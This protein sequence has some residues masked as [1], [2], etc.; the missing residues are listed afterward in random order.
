MPHAHPIRELTTRR[1][2]AVALV[3]LLALVAAGVLVVSPRAAQAATEVGLGTAADF[4]VLA[5]ETITVTGPTTINGDIGLHP[6]D[7]VT[8][9]DNVTHT[10]ELHVDDA[11]ALQAKNDLVTAYNDAAGQSVSAT[12]AT[13][14]G[15]EELVGGVYDSES[16]T[17]QLTNTLTLDGQGD[18]D[19]VWVF[20]MASTLTTA[21]DSEVVLINGANAC[22][23]FW[24]VGSSAALG[25]GTTFVGSIL[26]LTTITLDTSA[27]I[28]G[29]ALARNGETTM[30]TNTITSSACTTPTTDP[31]PDPTTDP[32][33][34]PTTEPE[35]DPTTEPTD[36][37]GSS[38]PTPSTD[39]GP[40]PTPSAS[41]SPTP[42]TSSPPSSGTPQVPAVPT[43][44]VPAG[45]GSTAI[46]SATGHPTGLLFI[47]LFAAL[48][49]FA[50]L[51]R[52]H[53]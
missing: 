30:D 42:T 36:T 23:V 12:I 2:G 20:Q 9:Y 43:G 15:G 14:L 31:D 44:P 46:T 53:A 24:Q 33:P 19:T 41:E 49:L 28:V 51:R 39:S 50:A 52:W 47:P 7:A 34:D 4:A 6:G 25:T 13:E 40:S 10:G 17:F 32:E 8:G 21:S 16:G 26:A 48:G 27:S 5:G 1:F 22:N 37:T 18:P 35:P 3:T 11:D 29:R 45:D 38:S